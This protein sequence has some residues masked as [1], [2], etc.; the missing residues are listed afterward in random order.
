MPTAYHSHLLFSVGRASR[1]PRFTVTFVCRLMVEMSK[2]S[3]SWVTVGGPATCDCATG[4]VVAGISSTGELAIGV[5]SKAAVE[6]VSTAELD[7][8]AVLDSAAALDSAIELELASAVLLLEETASAFEEATG[9]GGGL[10]D[11]L[12]LAMTVTAPE[13]CVA[14]V[15]GAD[16]MEL[17]TGASRKGA[18]AGADMG[19][20]FAGQLQIQLH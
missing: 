1:A 9:A 6:L 4:D 16:D 7:S 20:R 13:A 3:P 2:G 15:V 14:N 11:P 10:A 17:M 5:G 19:K 18:A 12:P 8:T